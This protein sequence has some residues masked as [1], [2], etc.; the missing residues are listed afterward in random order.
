MIKN[1]LKDGDEKYNED[2]EKNAAY[3][4]MWF[5]SAGS[6]GK[7]GLV[8]HNNQAI[9]SPNEFYAG[10]YA[11]CTFNLYTYDMPMSKGIA[12]GLQNIQ[13][14]RDGEPLGS[15]KRTKAEDDF[16]AAPSAASSDDDMADFLN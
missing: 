15:G 8:D 14:L 3:Q 12:V 4:G 9:I 11:R 1:P 2:P 16:D 6:I 13:K 7:P 5:M 10:C